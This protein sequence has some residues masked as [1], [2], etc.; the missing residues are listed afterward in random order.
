MSSN[1]V[2]L[3]TRNTEADSL[4]A[5]EKIV[6]DAMRE[7]MYIPEVAKEVGL[8][9]AD[10]VVTGNR[11]LDDDRAVQVLKKATLPHLRAAIEAQKLK[12]FREIQ[13]LNAVLRSEYEMVRGKLTGNVSPRKLKVQT[14]EEPQS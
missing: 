7:S 9:K 14:P 8:F 12:P 10:G 2:P 6:R 3:F 4:R 11:T 13:L 5:S 1:F